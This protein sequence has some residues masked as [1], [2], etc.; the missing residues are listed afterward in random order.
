ML[1]HLVQWVLFQQSGGK[2]MIKFLRWEIFLLIFFAGVQ[3][4]DRYTVTMWGLSV[5]SVE[6]NSVDSTFQN[7]LARYISFST[8]TTSFMSSFFHVDNHYKLWVDPKTYSI[9]SFEK[10]TTQPKVDNTLKTEIIDDKIYY[11]KTRTVIPK[12]VFTIFSLLDYIRFNQF[13]NSFYCLLERE[14]QIFPAVLIPISTEENIVQY[15]LDID[16]NFPQ[17]NVSVVEHTD[18]FSWAIYK[19]GVSRMIKVNYNTQKIESCVFASGL[20]HLT[21]KLQK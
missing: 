19:E 14:G 21:A 17:D 12:D 7:N 9:R 5:A 8:K 20:V 10:N 2:Q 1:L 15:Q 18:I 13:T 3:G 16:L 6:I 4:A 11:L